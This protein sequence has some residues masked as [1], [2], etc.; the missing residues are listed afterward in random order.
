M[1][2]LKEQM[3][4]IT[5]RYNGLFDLDGLYA[6]VI[7]WSKNYGY[8][9]HEVDYKHKVPGKGAEQEMKWQITKNVNEY[10]AFEVNFIIHMWDLVEVEIEGAQKNLSN[11]RFY[12]HLD[13]IIKYDWQEIEKGGGK[14]KFL[15]KWYREKLLKRDLEAYMDMLYY[16]MWNLQAILKKYFDMQTKKYAYKGYL[17][18]N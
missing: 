6:A 15:G 13:G 12:I 8:M 4:R 17:G 7:D 10:V 18:E 11:A 1:P 14:L 9:W 16:R 2:K 3:P 5:L